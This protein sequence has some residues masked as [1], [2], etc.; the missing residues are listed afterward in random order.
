MGIFVGIAFLILGSVSLAFFGTAVFERLA[1]RRLV[2][3]FQKSVGNPLFRRSAGN[4]RGY[5]LVE[6]QGRRT[7]RP[8]LVPVG[9]ALRGDVFWLVAADGRGAQYVKNIDA[10]PSVRVKV[11]SRWRTGIAHICDDDN[12]HKRLLRLNPLN[13]LFIW[14][15]GTGLLTVRIDLEPA[16]EDRESTG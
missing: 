9:G 10:N 12:P 11:R 13:S 1:P 15:A 6:T 14:V 16:R 2:R 5:A 8:H 4:G 7:G 3:A